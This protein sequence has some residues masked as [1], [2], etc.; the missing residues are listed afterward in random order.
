ML[1]DLSQSV[2][3]QRIGS[4][5]ALGALVISEALPNEILNFI[6]LKISVRDNEGNNGF[7][8]FIIRLSNNC[9]FSDCFVLGDDV[10][11]FS[12]VDVESS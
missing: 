5:R 3:R 9:A 10:F 12:R 2:S 4:V 11:N 6:I 8:P 1:L 7:P